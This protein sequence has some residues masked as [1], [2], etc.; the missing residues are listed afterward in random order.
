MSHLTCNAHK[1][2]VVYT[3]TSLIHRNGKGDRCQKLDAPMDIIGTTNAIHWEPVVPHAE[4]RRV[5][6]VEIEDKDP[7]IQLM[8]NIFMQ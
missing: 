3:E 8:E 5:L 2:R 1:K 7:A 4:I 6:D